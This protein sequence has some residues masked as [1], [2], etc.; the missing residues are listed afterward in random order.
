MH[1]QLEL[2]KLV[3]TFRQQVYLI[4]FFKTCF[5]I[6]VLFPTKCLI[7]HNFIFLG[8]Y[9]IHVSHKGCA[10]ISYPATAVKGLRTVI[11]NK[12][13]LSVKQK[14][15]FLCIPGCVS[16]FLGSVICFS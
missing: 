16:S 6:S 8:S 4:V 13:K 11:R 1:M 5:T 15:L 7:F 2:E 10:K 12:T 3:Y 9:N 14:I